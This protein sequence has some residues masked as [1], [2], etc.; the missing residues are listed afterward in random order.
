MTTVQAV[1][2]PS[3][4][5]RLRA[6]V[7]A[8][9][10]FVGNSVVYTFGN[11][12]PQV[13]NL[14]LLPVLTR[15][16]TPGEYGVY[17]YTAAA[18]A[19]LAIM[20][21]LSIHA[22]LLSAFY[23][24]A[25]PVSERE[26]F[27]AIF[28][29]LAGYGALF[30]SGA[31]LIMPRIMKGTQ[32]PFEPYMRLAL[33]NLF[34][35][36]FAIIPLTYF[37]IRQRAGLFVALTLTQFLINAGVSLLFVVKWRWG[38]L[39]RY[40][41][42]LGANAALFIPYV[43]IIG[44]ISSFRFDARMRETIKAAVTFALPMAA[45]ELLFSV[46]GISDRIILERFVP[47]SRL[48]I[49]SVGFSLASGIQFVANGIYRAIEPE[50]F[51]VVGE[52]SAEERLVAMKSCIVWILIVLASVVVTFSREAVGLL[53]RPA[54]HEAY[55][56]TSIVAVSALI[57]GAA[58]PVST[59]VVA[60]KKT[61][62]VPIVCLASAAVSVGLN[63]ILIPVMGIYGAAVAG[64]GAALASLAAYVYVAENASPLRWHYG[65]DLAMAAAALGG[66]A[67]I[68]RLPIRWLPAAF[69]AK[70]VAVVIWLIVLW[71]VRKP[72]T[73]ARQ[74]FKCA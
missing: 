41:G 63:L 27:G 25:K 18:C 4:A 19:F 12:A 16:L 46:S 31:F 37:R 39:G 45:A 35:E 68:Q 58:I 67:L 32:V 74:E 52:R 66:C 1:T 29:F 50:I 73:G 3:F 9:D 48:G 6:R 47:M 51:R 57:Q 38:I 23:D 30:V 60:I 72:L 5:A 49:Y 44:R 53:V 59:Y 71:L 36:L 10:R 70:A 26:L 40:Y 54:F 28:F 14:A 62:A 24:K 34:L 56:V 43:I 61:R 7:R 11:M 2:E 55:I 20:A 65:G 17:A 15:F 21:H 33:C 8:G 64:I 22:Y 13:I 42:Q 69:C